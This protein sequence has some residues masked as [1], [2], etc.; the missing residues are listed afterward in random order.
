MNHDSFLLLVLMNCDFLNNVV[1][2]FFFLYNL[3]VF[4]E[5]DLCF[6]FFAKRKDQNTKSKL[7]PGIKSEIL[8]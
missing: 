2:P 5:A 7:E 3:L 4:F 1:I 8:F 6:C